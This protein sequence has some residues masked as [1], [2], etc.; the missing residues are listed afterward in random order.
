MRQAIVQRFDDAELEGI[1]ERNPAARLELPPMEEEPRRP[2]TAA[3]RSAVLEVAKT[4]AQGAYVL[5][6]LYCGLR[7][8]ECL[9]L[10]PSDIDL[11]LKQ[12]SVTKSLTLNAN[13]G[14]ITGT[15][16]VK[17]RRK[18]KRG[19]DVG[20]RIVPIPDVLLPVLV[21]LCADK[22]PNAILFAKKTDGKHATQQ[23]VTWWWR[24]FVRQCHIATGAKLHRNAIQYETSHFG[25]EVTPHYLRHTYAT[26]IYAAGADEK[27]RKIFLGHA[28]NDV[29][30]TYTAMSEDAFERAAALI[31]EYYNKN[32]QS[33]TI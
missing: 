20:A 33:K 14:E 9:A 32:E 24:S 16:A 19:E 22:S 11:T 27:A 10:Q 12:I 5:I 4:H 25:T 13:V 17:M 18:V 3:E 28:S 31:N 21:E 7:R 15:K 8:G 26:D 30:D 1:I 23:T 2:L 29:T 6:M